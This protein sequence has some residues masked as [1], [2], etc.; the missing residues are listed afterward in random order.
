MRKVKNKKVIRRLANK[1]FRSNQTRNMIAVLAIALTTMLF[2][3]IF[4]I[5]LG[6]IESFQLSTM[7]QSG[8]NCHGVFKN[9]TWE[10]YDRLKDHPSIKECAPCILAA[11]DIKNP[12]F[13]KRHVEAWYMPAYHYPHCFLN[14]IDGKAPEKPQEI[15][16]DD[17]SLQLLGL[18]AKA[19]QEVTLEMQLGFSR[20]E[21]I[22]RTFYVSGVLQSDPAFN[23]GFAIVSDAYLDTY[24]DELTYTYDKDYSRVGAIRMDVNFSNSLGIQK[25]LDKVIRDCGYSTDETQKD[26][27]ESNANWAYI[28]DGAEADPM[29]MAAMAAGLLLVLFTGYLIIYNVFQI[30]VMKDIRYYGLLKTV[31]TTGR[32]VKKILRHQAIWLSVLGIPLGILAG[33]FIGKGIVPSI[34]ASSAIQAETQV[35]FH[36]LILVGAT[37]FSALTVSISIGKPSRIAA[38]V[39]PVEAVR[40]TDNTQHKK[41]NP[42]PKK[43]TKGGRI[44]RMALASLSWNRGRTTV[45]II[46]LSLAIILLNSVFTLTDSFD[47]DMYLK[48]FSTFDVLIGNARYF[49]MDTYRGSTDT[50]IDTE[51]LSDSFIDACA[52]QDGF[53]EAGRIY[54]SGRIGLDTTTYQ[55]P[56]SAKQDENGNFYKIINGIKIEYKTDQDG[57]LWDHTFLYGLDDLPLRTVEVWKGETDIDKIRAKLSTGKYILC[58]V[59][60]DDNDVPMEET[61][62]H[63]P[64]DQITL[65]QP[66]G[67]KRQFEVLSLIKINYY[68]ISCRRWEAFAYYTTSDIFREMESD[69]YLMSCAIDV[70]D[71]KEADFVQF[72]EQY[73]TTQEP[74][75]SYESKQTYLKEFSKMTDLFIL[76]GGVLSFVIG[77][78]GI[79][80]FINTILT[81][82]V[83]RQKEFAMMEAIGMTKRQLTR[84]L[85]LEGLYYAGI[86]I[87][88]SLTVGCLFSLTVVRILANGIWFMQ[89]HFV[90][91]PMLAVYPFLLVLSMLIPYLVYLPQR[92]IDVVYCLTDN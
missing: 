37:L 70:A 26:Y 40:Y 25:N 55:A 62:M 1:S 58:G 6:T 19:G 72:V 61:A 20:E 22:P 29:T 39:S 48:R 75:M 8:G 52:A 43:S 41:K 44:S 49:G 76:I 21:T 85:I 78:I 23:V 77:M 74:L 59:Q 66:D 35:S 92:K 68:S 79:L 16:M 30:S 34:I 14:I 83:S 3:T 69:K 67:T 86:T 80:N 13:L 51:N 15:L 31:G 28:S 88:A 50:T 45:V 36:P 27:I 81:G 57:I 56:P 24:A 38:K 5:G 91:G 2:T 90:L 18:P 9:L 47:M 17:M 82:I 71:D 87:A 10:Q 65:V 32:Q 46:S 73:T 12:E 63:L 7:R 60:T 42:K 54:G 53:Q 11:E 84:M 4:T 33:F 89:Y 64:G